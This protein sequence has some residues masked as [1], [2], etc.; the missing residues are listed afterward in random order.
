MPVFGKYAGDFNSVITFIK[1]SGSVVSIL[2]AIII[3]RTWTARLCVILPIATPIYLV[4]STGYDEYY[5]FVAGLFLV[6]LIYAIETEPDRKNILWIAFLLAFLPILYLPF[7]VTSLIVLT[8]YLLFY[9]STR[10]ILLP[11]FPSIYVLFVFLLWPFDQGDYIGSVIFRINTGNA[12]PL[13][14]RY[15]DQ[16]A[17][18]SI[19]FKTEY[20]L[21][22]EHF[23][24]LTYMLLWSGS[25]V[26]SLLLGIGIYNLVRKG[27]LKAFIA[28]P[29]IPLLII[30]FVWQSFYFVFMAPRLGPMKDID[31][32]F[33]FYIC[34]AFT[35]GYVLD[36]IKSHAPFD[37][38]MN[39]MVIFE[40]TA[41]AIVTSFF[42]VG[43]GI[44]EIF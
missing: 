4:F 22:W 24:D 33:S 14:S 1:I 41:N 29:R 38:R 7:L 13:Y 19:F 6:L 17:N 2:A 20:A 3:L 37:H 16:V 28:T 11:A 26:I 23:G 39:E 44:P 34:L 42:L 8:Y 12:Y 35:A 27:L 21:T 15:L 30:L 32:F 5:P 31:L 36:F 10:W 18:H 40:V 43:V 25:L 9:R